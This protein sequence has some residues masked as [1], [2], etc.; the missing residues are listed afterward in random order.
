[1]RKT[2]G[3]TIKYIRV[4]KQYSQKNVSTSIISRTSLS[5][6]ENNMLNPTFAKLI[7]IINNLDVDFDEFL[8]IQ[9][10]F[11]YSEKKIIIN[12]FSNINFN[13]DIANLN[14]L[15]KL[16]TTYLKKNDGDTIINEIRLIAKALIQLNSNHSIDEIRLTITPIWERLSYLDKWF[17]IELN[18]INNILF[19]FDIETSIHICTRAVK[20]LQKYPNSKTTLQIA[21]LLNTSIL[22]MH[23][24]DF[25]QANKYLNIALKKC[26]KIKRYDL[27]SITLIRLAIT[28]NPLN[29]TLLEKGLNIIRS[30]GLDELLSG[31]Q[32]EICSFICPLKKRG[33]NE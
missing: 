9:N 29:L 27:L 30:I 15:L 31:I 25:L 32:D 11:K 23:R 10:N 24:A 6:I 1:M 14:H 22:L 12:L 16:C 17:G 13:T 33:I 4:N 21:F 2:I 5:K 8:Y 26:E 20:E 7:P 18:I 3:D 28:N 19:I